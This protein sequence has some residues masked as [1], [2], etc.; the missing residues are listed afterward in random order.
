MRSSTRHR[1]SVI[2]LSVLALALAAL[3][4]CGSSSSSRQAS[5]TAAAT[6]AAKT[7]TVQ[8]PANSTTG[9]QWTYSMDKQ[10]VLT[11]A[12]SDYITPETSAVGV[13]GTQEYVFQAS[14]D[15]TVTISFTYVRSW[16]NTD[17]DSTATYVFTVKD[18]E[19]N[20]DSV[21]ASYSQSLEELAGSQS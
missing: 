2:V 11:E 19:I 21:T 17:T 16:E 6:S 5:S 18:G 14:G 13:G 20:Q 12:S 8:L 3:V 9:Y 15:G 4:G 10:G 1:F 7:T